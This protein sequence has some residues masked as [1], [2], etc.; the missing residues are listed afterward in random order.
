MDIFSW[1]ALY[2]I[3]GLPVPLSIEC[4]MLLK[5][6]VSHETD[7]DGEG[8]EGGDEKENVYLKCQK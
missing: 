6:C 3:I 7:R 5:A 8:M 4:D 1:P 2:N